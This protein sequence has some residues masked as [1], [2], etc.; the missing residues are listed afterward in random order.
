MDIRGDLHSKNVAGVR[1]GERLES[2]NAKGC[3]PRSRLLMCLAMDFEEEMFTQLFDQ[4][5]LT[6]EICPR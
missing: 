6:I 5:S 1:S 2:S 4:A 3:L